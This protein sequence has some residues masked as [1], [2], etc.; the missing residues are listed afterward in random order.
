MITPARTHRDKP[1]RRPGEGKII[2]SAIARDARANHM[3]MCHVAHDH[4]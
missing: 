1:A 3:M 2:G 4:V